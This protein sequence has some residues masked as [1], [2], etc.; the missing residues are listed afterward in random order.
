MKIAR[1]K[2][3]RTA[4]APPTCQSR[5]HS[6]SLINYCRGSARG[7]GFST[8]IL[9]TTSSDR[10]AWWSGLLLSPR[11][12]GFGKKGL[13][14]TLSQVSCVFNTQIPCGSE[15]EGSLINVGAHHGAA[16]GNV[17]KKRNAPSR[18]WPL[19]KEKKNIACRS[20]A[21]PRLLR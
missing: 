14:P 17:N 6:R 16:R 1:H 5:C 15:R 8:I 7:R 4:K 19:K 9:T 20:T 3:K 12:A 13:P 21:G 10:A 11:Q 2:A 18:T